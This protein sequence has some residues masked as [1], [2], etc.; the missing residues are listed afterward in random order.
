MSHFLYRGVRFTGTAF[1]VGLLASPIVWWMG[2]GE[3]DSVGDWTKIVVFALPGIGFLLTGIVSTLCKA[4]QVLSKKNLELATDE[5]IYQR[6]LSLASV[7]VAGSLGAV[8]LYL[9]V[10]TYGSILVQG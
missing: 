4:A 10:S 3:L 5:E 9:I 7:M 8:W 2:K 6:A 1:V